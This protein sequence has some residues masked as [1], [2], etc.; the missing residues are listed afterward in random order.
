MV[1]ALCVRLIMKVYYKTNNYSTKFEGIFMY[2][3]RQG[4]E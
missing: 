3:F 4:A 2:A 1:D